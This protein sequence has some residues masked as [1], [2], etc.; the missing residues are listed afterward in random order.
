MYKYFK[1]SELACRHT[2][3][4]GMDHG[5]MQKL[6]AIR[7]EC[8]FPFL[9]TSAYR[10]PSHPIEASKSKPGAHSSGKA[11]DIAVS[12]DKAFKVV[13]VALK[14][15]IKRIGIAQKGDEKTR[16]IHLDDDT[17]RPHPR[18]WSY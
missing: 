17:S 6:E 13:E 10:H 5:F 3:Q 2:G 15:G 12:M 16:F 9:L 14:H 7:E 18:V 1:D 11:V 4:Q 8:G